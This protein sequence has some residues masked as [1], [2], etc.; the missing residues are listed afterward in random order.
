MR[1][2][3]ETYAAML[4]DAGFRVTNAKLAILDVLG[5]TQRPLSID[6]LR[7]R[8]AGQRIDVATV[9]RTLNDFLGRDIVRQID[10]QHGHKHFELASRPEH[11]HVICTSCG[12]IVDVETCVIDDLR[13]RVLRKSG[14]ASITG[15]SLEFYGQCRSCAGKRRR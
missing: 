12:K 14:F 15:H 9:Y 10:L 4:R 11:H 1:T 3:R 5:R 8:L 2:I 13:G 6:L 7:Q